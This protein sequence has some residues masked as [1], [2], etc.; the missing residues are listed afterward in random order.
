MMRRLGRLAGARFKYVPFN[1]SAPVITHLLGGHTQAGVAFSDDLVR[2]SGQL[3][4]LAV[5]DAARFAAAPDAP[6]FQELG[7]DIVELVDRGVAVPRGTPPEVVSALEAAFLA[8]MRDPAV[9]EQMKK[10]GFVPLTMG[11]A[12]SAGHIA[13]LKTRYADALEELAE[14]S[15]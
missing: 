4:V 12:E 8:V 14:A 7:H 10:E 2:Y 5:A 9:P 1:G 6:T 3:R 15:P 11:S 13:L